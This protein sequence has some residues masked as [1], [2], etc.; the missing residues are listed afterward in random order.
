MAT[1]KK[2][3]CYDT[4]HRPAPMYPEKYVEDMRR[5]NRC[6]EWFLSS[7]I[8]NRRCPECDNAIKTNDAGPSIADVQT[9]TRGGWRG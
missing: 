7:W 2:Y 1:K 8:G 9:Q 4:C 3:P 6:G 5:C